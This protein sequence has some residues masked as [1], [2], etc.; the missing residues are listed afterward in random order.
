MFE[1]LEVFRMAQSMAGH[2][3]ARQTVVARNIAHVD[4]PGYK[5]QDIPAFAE[6]Y[7]KGETQNQPR[8]T[9]ETHLDFAPGSASIRART[10]EGSAAPNGNSVSLESELLK[11][12]E[13]RQQHDMALSIYR[14]GMAVLRA[15][16]GRR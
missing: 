13:I 5:A 12:A 4:T 16:L 9:R 1:R 11:S 15:S 2:A 10:G 8:R 6:L 3:G 14:S 7:R